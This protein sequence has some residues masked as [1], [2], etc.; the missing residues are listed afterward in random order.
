M[1]VGRGAYE[2]GEAPENTCEA[3]VETT[4]V[5]TTYVTKLIPK[6]RGAAISFLQFQQL[7]PSTQLLLWVWDAGKTKEKRDTLQWFGCLEVGRV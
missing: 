5:Q 7:Q 2:I 6:G 1:G 3:S 4:S